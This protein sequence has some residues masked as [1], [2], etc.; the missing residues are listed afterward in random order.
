MYRYYRTVYAPEV[1]FKGKGDTAII[2]DGI[3]PIP[4]K[5]LDRMFEYN[6]LILFKYNMGYSE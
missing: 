4:I 5:E 1:P 3:P 2:I 6:A